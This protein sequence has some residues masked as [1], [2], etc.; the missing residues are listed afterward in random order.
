MFDFGSTMSQ[1]S[2]SRQLCIWPTRG[3]GSLVW[4]GD[5][6]LNFERV[7]HVIFWNVFLPRSK[8]YKAL[9]NFRKSSIFL[10]FL[11]QFDFQKFPCWLRNRFNLLTG[12]VRGWLRNQIIRRQ[13]SWFLYESLNTLWPHPLI[14]H[15]FSQICNDD[16]F[17]I[18]SQIFFMIFMFKQQK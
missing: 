11:A 15:D 5:D 2:E 7:P 9:G 10:A 13:E 3:S 12:E 1:I 17:A 6:L 4:S 14:N 8:P 18:P 16:V